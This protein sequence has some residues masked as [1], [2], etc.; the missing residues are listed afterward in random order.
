MVKEHHP[1]SILTIIGIGAPLILLLF[2]L[3]YSL[4]DVLKLDLTPPSFHEQDII[5]PIAFVLSV[6]GIWQMVPYRRAR[7]WLKTTAT[8][9][10]I[11]ESS[12]REQGEHHHFTYFFPIVRYEYPFNGKKYQSDRVSFEVE[13]IGV[14]ELNNW[15]VKT[16][17]REKF[18]HGWAEGTKIEAFVNPDNA[19]ESVIIRETSRRRGSHHW[20]L[21]LS[22]VLLVGVWLGLRGIV[23]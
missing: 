9:I 11:E 12:Y 10:H 15:G 22:G 13:N 8:I 18:W 5:L 19:E 14:P 17:D 1:T 21:F 16:A 6:A 7:S 20:A 23:E 3:G 2:L 4:V